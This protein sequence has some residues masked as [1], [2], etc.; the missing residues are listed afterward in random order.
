MHIEITHSNYHATSSADNPF[1]GLQLGTPP[2]KKK[3]SFLTDRY[4]MG[5]YVRARK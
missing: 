3:Q 2:Q 4:S 1:S 5:A